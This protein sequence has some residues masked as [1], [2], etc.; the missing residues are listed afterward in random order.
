MSTCFEP[1]KSSFDCKDCY[2]NEFPSLPCLP[3]GHELEGKEKQ[4]GRELCKIEGA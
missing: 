4:I 3:F 1:R 2:T